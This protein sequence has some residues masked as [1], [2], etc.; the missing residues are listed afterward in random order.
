M[1]KE[2][3]PKCGEPYGDDP[4]W[5][6]KDGSDICQMCWEAECS[7]SWWGVIEGMSTICDNSKGD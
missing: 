1:S 7:E 2:L 4:I 5:P 3:C 6:S